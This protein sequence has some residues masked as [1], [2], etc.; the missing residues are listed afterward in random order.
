VGLVPG[1]ILAIIAPFAL[2]LPSTSAR[3]GQDAGPVGSKPEF[4]FG[5]F[6]YGCR[7]LGCQHSLSPLLLEKTKGFGPMSGSFKE[8]RLQKS[9]QKSKGGYNDPRVLHA[10]LPCHCVALI[11]KSC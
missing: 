6:A 4:K 5:L 7:Y 11:I 1:T 2:Y 9:L 8:K 10:L 3:S